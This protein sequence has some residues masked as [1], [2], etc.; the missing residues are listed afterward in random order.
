M[1]KDITEITY[2]TNKQ[3]PAFFTNSAGTEFVWKMPNTERFYVVRA[4]EMRIHATEASGERIVI[5]YTD[6]LEDFGIKT[7]ADLA[8]WS[9]SDPELF[10]WVNNSWFEV[11]DDKDENFPSEPFHTL[12]D[13][14]NY[15]VESYDEYGE[16][17]VVEW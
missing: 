11:Y 1:T 2:D 15:A 8:K 5:R 16:E 14:I 7:D 13:A 4:G 12:G 6:Q 9:E 10:D 17:G 3:D